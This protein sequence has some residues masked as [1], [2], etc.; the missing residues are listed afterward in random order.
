MRLPSPDT[1]DEGHGDAIKK[2][3]AAQSPLA[4]A[5]ADLGGSF[6]EFQTTQ[7]GWAEATTRLRNLLE[8]N[9]PPE[10]AVSLTLAQEQLKGQPGPFCGQVE[11]SADGGTRIPDSGAT[12]VLQARRRGRSSRS[13]PG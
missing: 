6:R 5:G 11:G 9:I 7:V 12:R 3:Q 8:G 10:T 1:K 13:R 4:A 2:L